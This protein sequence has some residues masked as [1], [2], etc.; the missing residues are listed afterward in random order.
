MTSRMAV[1]YPGRFV[2]LAIMAGSYATCLGP[3][4]NPPDSLPDDHPPTL[5][6]H[7]GAD[8]TVPIGSARKYET[9]LLSEGV[10][11]R[12]VENASAGHEWLPSAPGEITAW[13][14]DH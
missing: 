11:T 13:F 3:Q 1:S 9:L 14:E 10:E 2:A 8:T 12:F 6:L 5:M 4:C 7:G